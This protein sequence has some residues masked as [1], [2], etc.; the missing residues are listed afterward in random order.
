MKIYKGNIVYTKEKEQFELVENGY[1]AVGDDGKVVSVEREPKREFAD[2]S[3]IDFGDR[4]IIPGFTDLHLHP[5][6][7]PNMGLGYDLELMPWIETYATPCAEYF[8]EEDRAREIIAAFITDMWKFGI[9]RSVQFGPIDTKTTD[10]LFEMYM[11]SGLSCYLGKNHTDYKKDK[12]KTETTE[13]SIRDTLFLIDKYEGKSDLVH[14]ILT[15]SFAPGCTEEMMKWVG[16]TARERKIPIQTHLDENRTEV[17]MVKQRF[18]DSK[19]YADVYA[20]NGMID[21]DVPTIMA[22]CI[23][24]TEDEIKLIKDNNIFIA[25]CVHSNFDLASGIMSLR[26][27]LEE[28]IR[29]GLGSD[30]SGGHT[31][32]MMD[33]MRTTIEASKYYFVAEGKKP[34]S[35]SEAFYLATKGGG[36][37]FGKCGSFEPGYWFDALVIDDASL[38][39]GRK[40]NL[41][42]RIERF[43]YCGDDRQIVY[44]FC[45]GNEVKKPE[46][47]E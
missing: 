10:L 36:E 19:N 35:S 42:E 12:H 25:H 27:Y 34:I 16:E 23:H 18:P 44:R 20:Q 31:L 46:W 43:I 47:R 9:I 22:H 15:P 24:M 38:P 7:Y 21:P 13:E 17:Q 11:K 30:I 5:N 8:Q 1:V 33:T 28:G 6:Q 45:Q 37:F 39:V 29:V 2:A 41:K 4:I 14:Y 26:R 3:V 40:Y 32:N